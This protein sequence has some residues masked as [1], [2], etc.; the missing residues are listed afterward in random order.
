MT[1]TFARHAVLSD[2]L[3]TLRAASPFQRMTM[4]QR[5]LDAQTLRNTWADFQPAVPLTVAGLAAGG[6][7]F[8]GGSTLIAALLALIAAP[9]R[10]QANLSPLPLPLARAA[11]TPGRAD[12][13][14]RRPAT[15]PEMPQRPRLMGERRP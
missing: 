6:A 15:A 3:A 10:R 7:G 2:H 14:M 12:P 8:L 11:P 5:M 9:F 13:P 4:P 1:R